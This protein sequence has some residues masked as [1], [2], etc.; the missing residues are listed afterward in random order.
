MPSQPPRFCHS[1][2]GSK[3]PCH[4]ASFPKA[5]SHFLQSQSFLFWQLQSPQTFLPI[6]P[7]WF[8]S[9]QFLVTIAPEVHLLP[10]CFSEG[11]FR[12]SYHS[13]VSCHGS[14]NPR[15]SWIME[16]F[17]VDNKV[18]ELF[19][20]DASEVAVPTPVCKKIIITYQWTLWTKH[21]VSL[22]VGKYLIYFLCLWSNLRIEV[23]S[24]NI[25][26]HAA[27]K[28]KRKKKKSFQSFI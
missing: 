24:F 28:K 12:T 26:I 3:L 20:M 2:A 6:L 7:Q 21:K 19:V 10:K 22:C 11:L 1:C 27:I 23:Y 18:E 13:W 25:W 16:V 4:A 9:R 17:V 15:P 14:S 8:L 5:L